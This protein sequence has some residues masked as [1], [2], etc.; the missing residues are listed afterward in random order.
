M[1]HSPRTWPAA[2][3]I[4]PFAGLLVLANAAA[5]VVAGAASGPTFRS[6]A[7]VPAE[8]AQRPWAAVTYAF[9]HPSAWQLMLE[10]AALV[11]IAPRLESRAGGAALVGWYLGGALLAVPVGFIAPGEAFAG[12]SAAVLAVLV[13]FVRRRPEDAVIAAAPA[14]GRWLVPVL[15]AGALLPSLATGASAPVVIAHLSA[16]ALACLYLVR[17]SKPVPERRVELPNSHFN[18]PGVT[19]QPARTPWDAIELDALHEVNREAVIGVL[20]KARELGPSHLTGSEREFLDRMCA[21]S[22]LNGATRAVS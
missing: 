21:A 20:E 1:R 6:L 7:L 11:L 19:S 22:R 17:P 3:A 9:L 16:A 18:A 2:S 10:M 14:K 15:V 8:L 4:Q 13:G 12:S 5:F